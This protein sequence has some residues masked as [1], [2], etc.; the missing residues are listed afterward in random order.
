VPRQEEGTDVGDQRREKQKHRTDLIAAS[1]YRLN[2]PRFNL[3]IPKL[4]QVLMTHRTAA[5]LTTPND[6]SVFE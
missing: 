3:F 5:E 1:L 2:W 6:D 4:H